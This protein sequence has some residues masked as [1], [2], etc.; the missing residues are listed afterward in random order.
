M[1]DKTENNKK[2]KK[3][4]AQHGRARNSVLFWRI[5]TGILLVAVIV[6][7]GLL[8][9]LSKTLGG[10]ADGK[11]SFLP[12]IKPEPTEP[13]VYTAW[14][15][16][17]DGDP[18]SIESEIGGRITLP[19]GAP[20]DGYTF[21]CWENSNGDPVTGSEARI[22]E[23]TAFRAVYAIAFRDES[24]ETDHH[25][26][27]SLDSDMLFHPED[28]VSRGTAAELIYGCLDTN[29]EGSGSFS[30]VGPSA[31]CSKAVA[32]LKDLGVIGGSRFHPDEPVSLGDFL[33]ILSHFFPKSTAVWS[34][35]NIPESDA[36]YASFCL[37]MEKGWIDDLSVSP[38]RDL[39]RA[40]AAHILNMLIHRDCVT[41]TDYSMVGTILDVSFR[42]P[43][44]WDIAESVLLHKAVLSESGEVWE[45]SDAL[46]LHEEG[47]YFDGTKL[48]CVDA[49][50]SALVNESYGSFNF[51]S[52]GVIT[53]GMPE[54]DACVQASLLE[55]VDPE[56]LESDREQVLRVLF[57][58]VTYHNSYLRAGDNEL[59]DVGDTS[60]V[61]D[62]A[63]RMFINK[64][65]CCYNYAAQFYVLARAIGYDAVIYSGT[66]NPPATARA[67]GW[68]EIEFDGVPYIF[69]TELEYTQVIFQHRGSTY[70]KMTYEKAKGWYYY[71][72]EEN[73]SPES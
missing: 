24:T 47:M 4:S 44:F 63:Y 32:T 33:D 59:H 66:I 43:Y 49:Q 35:D 42:H 15:Y 5:A 27:F 41:E 2:G 28:P 23:E 26:Y 54:L 12:E 71:R 9:F 22:F 13:A 68:V 69:D 60:W 17:P 62:A 38:D 57:N 45:S 1:P 36:R 16:T 53:T 72:G 61:N 64:K 14:F 37:A 19:E 39:T 30:D 31:S 48:R 58:Y 51:G 8:L 56:K 20:I 29:I 65:G 67:H 21:I 18:F 7:A 73:T 52:D 46:P 70:F 55:L 34:F 11:A 3:Y 6:M 25:P 40:E 50:G 10:E